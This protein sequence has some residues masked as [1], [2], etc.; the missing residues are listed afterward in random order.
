[1]RIYITL[2]LFLYCFVAECQQWEITELPF[3]LPEPVSNNAVAY[4]V[5]SGEEYVYSF[6]GIDESKTF[7]GIHG[8]CFRVNLTTGESE[9]LPD[10]PDTLGKIA[11]AASVIG[12]TIYIMGGYHVFQNGSEKSSNKVHRFS[13]SENAFLDDGAAIPVPIDDQ[14]QVVY[15]NRYILLITGWSDFENVPNVQL[16]DTMT[17]EW[18][19][20]TNVPDNNAYNSFGASGAIIGD[21]IY[22]FGGAAFGQSFPIQNTLRKGAIQNQNP[23]D[24]IWEHT[25]TSHVGYRMASVASDHQIHWI[26]G[27]NKTY[28]YNG[29]AY[30][31][32][33]GVEPNHRILS[34]TT[35]GTWTLQENESFIPMDLR[36]LAIASNNTFYIAGGM[37][38]G[39]VV[40]DKILKLIFNPTSNTTITHKP[41]VLVYP[42]P[43]NQYIRV[44]TQTAAHVTIYNTMGKRL[45][46][47]YTN[48]NISIKDLTNGSYFY[49]LKIDHSMVRGHFSVGR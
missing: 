45:I 41:D 13:I 27:S 48:E 25:F 2:L 16:Y 35:D 1:M 19:E 38:S 8:R 23:Q 28:N 33:G 3:A 26:G 46:V 24:I 10:L 11:A 6:G 12:D 7:D 9:Y 47:G 18:S 36:G 43:A 5:Q 17:D 22:Y 21:T 30:N 31:G 49:S 20:S 39:Q 44:E 14:V 42:N 29:I 34:R 15:K 37:E 40:S 32:T 4:D